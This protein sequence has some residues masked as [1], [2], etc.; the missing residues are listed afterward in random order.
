M[1]GYDLVVKGGTVVTEG[2]SVP[3]EI[4]VRDGRIVAIAETLDG[5]DEIVD[6]RGKLVLPGGIEAHC[7]IA[8]ESANGVMT[9]DDYESGSISALYGG[10]TCFVPFAAQ[11]KGMGV[12]ETLDLYDERATGR[13]VIDWSYHLIISDPTEAVLAELPE[14]FARGVTSFKVFMTYPLMKIDDTAFL[15]ILSVAQS[16]G[17]LTMVHAENDGMIAWMSKQLLDKGLTAPRNHAL[18]HPALAEEEAIHRAIS[19][20]KLVDAPLMIVHVSTPEGAELVRRAQAD[21]AKVF[22]ETCPQYLF[23]TRNDLDRPGLEGAKYMCSPP[24]RDAATQEALWGHLRGGTLDLFS[25][26]HAPYRYD[27]SGKLRAGPEASFKQIANG[28]PGLALRL[29]LLF[30]EGVLKGRITLQQFVRLS[31]ANQARIYGLHPKKGS[32]SVGADADIA[33]WDPALTRAVR[34]EDQHDAMDYTPFEGRELTG[35]PETVITRGAVALSGGE[36]RVAPG[37]GRYIPRGFP[38][39]GAAPGWHAPEREPETAFGP[40]P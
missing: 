10:N 32:L 24:V 20:A 39:L 36:L 15:E 3:A 16:H 19:L 28:M 9:A 1:A 12:G 30:S 40:T 37:A 5:G 38:D 8:Q 25:S 29:P 31:T 7:H 4:G 13:S 35:W 6:A 17:A 22:G 21:G 11:R 18:S 2:E 23:L 34:A 14:A 26:D 33:I 27:E